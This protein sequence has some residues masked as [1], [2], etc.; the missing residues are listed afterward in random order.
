MSAIQDILQLSDTIHYQSRLLK[1]QS[2]IIDQFTYSESIWYTVSNA[3]SEHF[4][5]VS[6]YLCRRLDYSH[7]EMCERPYF[8]FMHPK[9]KAATLAAM[10]ELGASDNNRYRSFRNRYIT[11]SGETVYLEWMDAIKLKGGSWLATVKEVDSL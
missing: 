1:F 6:P 2:A 5:L 9:C 8:D 11:K 3:E 4:E 7:R 10:T